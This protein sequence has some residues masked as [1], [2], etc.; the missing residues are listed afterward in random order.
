VTRVPLVAQAD[1]SAH[2]TIATNVPLWI[3]FMI[4]RLSL[5][6]WLRRPTTH[7]EYIHARDARRE[8]IEWTG[9]DAP[10]FRE[11]NRGHQGR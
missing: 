7:R 3:R 6:P 9:F 11:R 1:S 5:V 10:T 2:K 8:R 4:D